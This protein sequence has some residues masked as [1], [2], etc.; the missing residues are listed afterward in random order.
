[1][2]W[3]NVWPTYKSIQTNNTPF[4][5]YSA[6]S[7]LSASLTSQSPNSTNANGSINSRYCSLGGTTSL[8]TMSICES[9]LCGVLG[10]SAGYDSY[11]VILALSAGSCCLALLSAG[12]NCCLA[13]SAGSNCVVLRRP[14]LLGSWQPTAIV[15]ISGL[16]GMGEKKQPVQNICLW[17]WLSFEDAT[18]LMLWASHF[19]WSFDHSSDLH[20][21]KSCDLSQK[22]T[23]L[24][25][26][27]THYLI[28]IIVW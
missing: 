5:S 4:Q 23:S 6:G 7:L 18:F 21:S 19:S 28:S 22:I 16:R 20:R 27:H 17:C 10:L 1:M 26:S 3:R 2:S 24:S 12:S 8:A 15:R 9:L 11:I 14:T 13:L 25:L